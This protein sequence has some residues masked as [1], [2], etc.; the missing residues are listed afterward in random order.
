MTNLKLTAKDISLALTPTEKKLIVKKFNELVRDNYFVNPLFVAQAHEV[1]AKAYSQSLTVVDSTL[2]AKINVKTEIIIIEGREYIVSPFFFYDRELMSEYTTHTSGIVG[3]YDAIIEKNYPKEKYYISSNLNRLSM[4]Y[5]NVIT[6]MYG[7]LRKKDKLRTE[8]MIEGLTNPTDYRDITQFN[9]TLFVISD[10]DSNKD[11]LFGTKGVMVVNNKEEITLDTLEIIFM[12]TYI[13][14][15]DIFVMDMM[16]KVTHVNEG[17][18]NM[19]LEFMKIGLD[20][21]K[22][23]S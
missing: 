17:T 22:S 8:K 4:F 11:L 1:F 13:C 21:R 14:V 15:L 5:T 18:K 10:T 12:S 9:E 19:A 3:R 6:L 16:Y 20:G 2:I 7:K 23:F